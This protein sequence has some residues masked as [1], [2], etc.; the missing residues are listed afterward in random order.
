MKWMVWI[1]G[2]AGCLLAPMMVQAA[3]TFLRSIAVQGEA[4]REVAP[5]EAVL[6]F[7]IESKGRELAA[8]KQAQDEKIQAL[9]RLAGQLKIEK[10]HLETRHAQLHPQYRYHEGEQH[11]DGYRA[12]T[13]VTMTLTRLDLVGEAM[14]RLVDAGFDRLDNVDYRVGDDQSIREELQLEALRNAKMKAGN[15]AAALGLKLGRAIT[16]EESGA[17]VSPPLQPVMQTEAMMMHSGRAAASKP[18]APPSGQQE[19]RAHVS[20]RFELM[21]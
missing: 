13:G 14:Q 15:M 18:V 2:A 1:I 4:T 3:D 5:D 9:Y 6:A 19:I 16:I 12:S 10:K 17:H 20:V 7:T 21:E 11:F 8:V